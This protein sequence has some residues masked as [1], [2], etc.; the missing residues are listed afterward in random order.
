MFLA[1]LDNKI[2]HCYEKKEW[3]GIQINSQPKDINYFISSI[4][5][6]LVNDSVSNL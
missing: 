2:L 4:L 6:V 3:P 1:L 5:L